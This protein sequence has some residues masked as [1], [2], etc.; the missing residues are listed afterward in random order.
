MRILVLGG[1]GWLGRHIASS[2]L[3]PGYDVTCLARGF[4]GA[5]PA[6]AKHVLADR[7][8]DD[9]YDDVAAETWDAVIDVT[10]QPGHVRR[11]AAALADRSEHFVFV[12]SGSVYADTATLGADES[13]PLLAPLEADV[14]ESLE[15]Y[16]EAKV[17]CENYVLSGYGGER[18]AIIRAGLIGGPGDVSDRSGYWP[19]RFSSP[20]AADGSVLVPDSPDQQVQLVDVRDLA[21][22]IVD[23]A[24]RRVPGV[25]NANGD[26]I[27]LSAHLD[28]ARETAGHT[29]PVVGVDQEWIEWHDISPW[30]GERSFPLWLPL[31]AY[32]GFGAR[33]NGRAR[34]AGLV[35]RELRDTLA[36]VL[37]WEQG[38]GISRLRKAGLTVDD[39]QALLDAAAG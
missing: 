31:P 3:D 1:T 37:A 4:S 34:S 36:D 20:A 27:P 8:A 26:A 29:G 18:S 17:A 7:D 5:I 13:A 23:V 11:A 16:G 12:S 25:F 14:M 10:R 35:T 38:A 33:D 39:E 15:S 22:W 28:V 19:M 30:M 6:G 32:A 9:A 21:A 2:A 24:A